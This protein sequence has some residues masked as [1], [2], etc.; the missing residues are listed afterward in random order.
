MFFGR[1]VPLVA[2]H[3]AG[4]KI[5]MGRRDRLIETAVITLVNKT[6][7]EKFCVFDFMDT[8]VYSYECQNTERDCS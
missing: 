5:S 7:L 2:Q 1:L 4:W 3:G 8:P 6:Q